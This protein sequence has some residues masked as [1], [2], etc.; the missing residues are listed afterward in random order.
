MFHHSASYSNRVLRPESR[1]V[2]TRARDRTLVSGR[3]GVRTL[4]LLASG[5][6]ALSRR[7]RGTPDLWSHLDDIG[8][9]ARGFDEG[10]KVARV[11]RENFVAVL[12]KKRDSGVDHVLGFRATE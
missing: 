10:A 8:V 9:D 3:L 12:R 5:R 6:I 4:G 7:L 1:A 2:R 11:F